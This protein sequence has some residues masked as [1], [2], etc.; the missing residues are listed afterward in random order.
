MTRQGKKYS[1]VWVL[2]IVFIIVCS[3]TVIRNVLSEI[4]RDA[5][6]YVKKPLSPSDI[7]HEMF[8]Y[9]LP[10]H[11]QEVFSGNVSGVSLV[12]IASESNTSPVIMLAQFDTSV[13]NKDINSIRGMLEQN[14]GRQYIEKE[15]IKVEKV[16]LRGED[17]EIKTY[18]GKEKINLVIR[19]LVVTF[20]GK[21]GTV[22]M[23]IVGPAGLWDQKAIDG[24][25]K[26]I[27]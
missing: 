16:N 11:Y 5:D 21:N 7:A 10:P 26:S 24:F 14:S 15:L 18:E 2:G 23:V 9:E 1:W 22:M 8:D 20:P 27:R 4:G 3:S 6:E 25:I 12:K 19:E 17:V 13:K